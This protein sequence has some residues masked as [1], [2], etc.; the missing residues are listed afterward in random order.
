M[1]ILFFQKITDNFEIENKICLFLVRGTVKM[2]ES[3]ATLSLVG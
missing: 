3:I 1:H 2:K